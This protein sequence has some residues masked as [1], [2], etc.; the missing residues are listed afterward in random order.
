MDEDL[1][2]VDAHHH[3]WDLESDLRYPSL[4]TGEHIW[5]GDHSRIGRT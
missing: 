3:L 5:L 2:I 1:P 4:Q